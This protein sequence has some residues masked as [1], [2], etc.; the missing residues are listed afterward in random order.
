MSCTNLQ[1]KL[2]PDKNKTDCFSTATSAKE[3]GKQFILKN[4]SKSSVCKVKVDGCLIT[5]ME[6]KKCDYLFEV[7]GGK[8]YFLVELKGT[9]VETA[10]EQIVTTFDIL[11]A[12]IKANARIFIGVIVSSAVPN[13]TELK[14]RGLQERMARDKHLRIK[15]THIVHIEPI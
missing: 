2:D 9:D 13:A 7:E 4:K 14:F 10:V 8:A 5:D 1:K 6:T 3:K 12:K 15:K 11:N